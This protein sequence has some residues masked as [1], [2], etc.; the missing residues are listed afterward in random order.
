MGAV[1]FLIAWL[2]LVI[3]SSPNVANRTSNITPGFITSLEESYIAANEID[4]KP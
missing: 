2:M 1:L 3:E 4:N